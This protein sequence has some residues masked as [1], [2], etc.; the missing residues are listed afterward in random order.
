[1]AGS[2]TG[3]RASVD[4]GGRGEAGP[5]QLEAGNRHVAVP[6]VL[7]IVNGDDGAGFLDLL[8][9]LTGNAY[10]EGGE[11]WPM[12][13]EYSEGRIRDVKYRVHLYLWFDKG[14]DA[15]PSKFFGETHAEHHTALCRYFDVDPATVARLPAGR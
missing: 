3:R 10:C 9:V 12:F 11:V 6:N 14:K 13:L 7:A 1:M 5:D 4:A 2:A 8:S 15:A